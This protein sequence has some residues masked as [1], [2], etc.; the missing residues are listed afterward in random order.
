MG[1]VIGIDLGTTNSCLSV[2]EGGSY[3]ILENQEGERT[4]PSIVAFT[5]DGECLVGDPAKRQAVTNAQNT[6]YA[7]KRLIGRRFD[8]EKTKELQSKVPYKIVEADNGDAW[9]EIDGKKM[10]P[11]EVSA[12][13]LQKLKKAAEDYLGEEVTDA[14]ITVPAYFDDSQRQATKDAGTI[15][16]LNVL[17]VV[18]E[19]TAAALAYGL[20]KEGD[21]KV[22]VYDLGG[23]TFDVSI[24]ELTEDEGEQTFSVLS[25]NG[26]TFLGGED[27]DN[28]IIDHL[29]EEFAKSNDGMDL[30]KD[31]LALQRLK[32]AA[33]DAKKKLSTG[34]SYQ[35]NIP[36]ITAD[37]SGPKHL[38][39]TITRSTLENLVGD[40]IEK[41]IGP[42]KQALAD[43][44][45]TMNDIDEVIL[46]GGMTRMPKV[47]ETVKNF[48]GKEPNKSVNPD[49]VV[50]AGAALQGGIISGHIDNALLVDVTPLNIG[51]EVEGGL[52]DVL[53]KANSP[54]P[55]EGKDIYTTAK[56]NQM[57][58][59]VQ[60]FQGNRAQAKDNRPLGTF[61]LELPP[62]TKKGEPEIELTA[63]I[64]ANGILNVSAMDKSTGQ[65]ADITI[66]A[67]SGLSED[68]IEAMQQDAEANAAKDKE[69]LEKA[70][71]SNKIEA[72]L[73]VIDKVKT[74][75]YYTEAKEDLQ[76]GFN[77]AA[78]KLQTVKGSDNVKELKEAY[79]AFQEKL[80]ELGKAFTAAKQAEQAAKT[81]KDTAAPA[82]NADEAEKKA[83]KT[84]GGATPK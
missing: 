30:K 4:T 33:E 6:L 43:A 44:G 37:A 36:Y 62:G 54:M 34:Q 49:E 50:S 48:F 73:N 25:T 23:G 76:K 74:K 75:E 72:A 60:L 13:I 59:E 47:R 10:S 2:L 9:V 19:P 70:E 27:F 52:M 14:V 18:N 61:C 35:V 17:R 51:V 11:S 58:V 12:R 71:F 83:P 3:K 81:G 40:L 21:S 7:I 42:C 26:D 68:Q 66:K 69:V 31:Q 78:E 80:E 24:L 39:V 22:V 41:S 67:N 84:G 38:D 56:D 57:D 55:C 65:K 77:E 45:L 32:E 16:G 46:V 53:I 79:T 1:K 5:K 20:K 64:D 15:A 82:A 29:A 28:R 8:D 63:R